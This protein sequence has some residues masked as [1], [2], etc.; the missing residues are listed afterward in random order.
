MENNDLQFRNLAFICLAFIAF[1][2][3]P[4]WMSVALKEY[5]IR[6]I[7]TNWSLHYES[8]KV[9]EFWKEQDC[10]FR[11]ERTIC[12]EPLQWILARWIENRGYFNEECFLV[13][14]ALVLS[15]QGCAQ[16]RQHANI[17]QPTNEELTAGKGD[18]VIRL[19]KQKNLY[20][21]EMIVERKLLGYLR[22]KLAL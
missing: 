14:L 12:V 3:L 21:A 17:V 1:I 18:E 8:Q 7:L 20:S 19:E 4:F 5:S 22:Q 11:P 13:S 6:K 10:P 16:V 15:V 2:L 9:D